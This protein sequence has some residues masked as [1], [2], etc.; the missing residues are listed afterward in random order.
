MGT[1]IYG[2]KWFSAIQTDGSQLWA[3]ARNG[4][5]GSAGINDIPHNFSPKSG[6]SSPTRPW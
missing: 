3:W 5:I 6:L 4:T 2:K 1:D